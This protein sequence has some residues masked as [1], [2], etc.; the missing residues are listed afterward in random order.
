M[1]TKGNPYQ[2]GSFWSERTHPIVAGGHRLLRPTGGGV[3]EPANEMADE[4]RGT[5]QEAERGTG[6]AQQQLKQGLGSA[7]MQQAALARGGGPM[8]QRAAM[9]AGAQ[10]ASQGVGQGAML[11]QQE[12]AA[13]RAGLQGALQHQAGVGMGMEQL[14]SQV[15]QAQMMG[16]IQQ[17]RV[18]LEETAADREFGMGLVSSG[19]AVAGGLAMMSD[20]QLKGAYSPPGA[21]LGVG[22]GSGDRLRK[23][24]RKCRHR[25]YRQM[26]QKSPRCL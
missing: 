2:Q 18:N 26:F 15:E 12:L 1:P 16:N 24:H 6:M 9:M 14:R 3:F 23:N 22:G 5:V 19:I 11:Q 25:T 4:A 17:Q 10:Q 20:P 8:A 7:A 13:A 21:K